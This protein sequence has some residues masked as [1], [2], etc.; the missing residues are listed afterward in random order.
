ME[1]GER[2]FYSAL[3]A[4]TGSGRQHDA[5]GIALQLAEYVG[6]FALRMPCPVLPGA[7]GSRGVLRIAWVA[8]ASADL[9][10]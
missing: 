10:N 5:R 1:V 3:R 9:R 4:S 7:A 8:H 2:R 6:L